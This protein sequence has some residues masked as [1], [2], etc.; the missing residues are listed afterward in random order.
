MYM[1]LV[2]LH[3]VIT[4]NVI[5]SLMTCKQL[6][7]VPIRSGRMH[8]ALLAWP[9]LTHMRRKTLRVVLRMFE[10]KIDGK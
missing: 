2:I 10:F 3:T 4:S 6:E 7:A 5:G 8:S 9:G 1:T